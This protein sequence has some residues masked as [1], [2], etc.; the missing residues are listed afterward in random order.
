MEATWTNSA[1]SK[2]YTLTTFLFCSK[3]DNTISFFCSFPVY[4]ICLSNLNNLPL[5]FCSEGIP[6]TCQM[7]PS[8]QQ[9][10]Q[11]CTIYLVIIFLTIGNLNK[12]IKSTDHVSGL[13]LFKTSLLIVYSKYGSSKDPSRWGENEPESTEYFSLICRKCSV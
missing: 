10:D 9:N 7:S 5:G 8:F 4:C 3:C 13:C 1:S 12:N 6:R 2:G 11:V